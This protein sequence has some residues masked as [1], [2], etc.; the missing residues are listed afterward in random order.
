MMLARPIEWRLP[1]G[2]EGRGCRRDLPRG[3]TLIEL[4]VV[5]GIIAILAS[6]LLPS[7]SRAKATAQRIKCT[8]NIKQLNLAWF[9]YATE[10]EEHM[11]PNGIGTTS[12]EAV[13]LWVS[14]AAH[15]EVESFTNINYLVHPDYASF[16][17]YIQDPTLYRCPTD[18]S[19]VKI[20]GE[21]YPKVRSY[22]LNTYLGYN[23]MSMNS[24][25]HMTFT[26]NADLART[27]PSETFT[28]LDVNPESICFAGFVVD[29]RGDTFFHFPGSYHNGSAVMGFADGRVD[30]QR[31]TDRR[32]L[33][34][35]TIFHY[36]PMPNNDDLSWLREHASI[37]RPEH[38]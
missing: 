19:T 6:L 33:E 28:F 30:R 20:K 36:S 21:L 32:T 3:F 13:K 7:L 38:R 9:L 8:S 24:P 22:S 5:I 16:S 17:S 29:M 37:L 34:S 31:W 18:R 10:H 2:S 23:A 26:K 14:G 4:L 15:L 27:S 35:N 11:P 1:G 25:K 12:E